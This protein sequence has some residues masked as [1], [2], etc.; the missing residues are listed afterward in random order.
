MAIQYS[1]FTKPWKKQTLEELGELVAG[2]GFDAVEYPLRG[3]Y[4]VQP[5]EGAAGIKRLVSTLKASGVGVASIACGIDVAVEDGK[6]KV[7]GASEDLFAA[8]GENGIPIIRI[9]QSLDSSKGFWDNYT[10]LRQKYD[11]IAV[12]AQKHGVTLGVQMHYGQNDIAN[13]YDTY[14]FLKDY[15]PKCI[16]AVWDAGHSGLAGENPRLVLDLLWNQLC[17]VNFKNA[18][19]YRSNMPDAERASWGVRWTT[20]PHGM[21]RWKTAVDY[22]KERGYQGTICLPAEY[23]DEP[24]VDRLTKFDIGYIKGLFNS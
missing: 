7:V 20:G 13:S 12:M 4:Q 11:A 21:C 18:Y 17:M 3:G 9:C 24:S 15:D 14:I 2:F 5:E 6:G 8:C 22:L 19:W 23:T 10:S 1:V 16:A